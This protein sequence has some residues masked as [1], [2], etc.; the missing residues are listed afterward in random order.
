ME[1]E[2]RKERGEKGGNELKVRSFGDYLGA[3]FE[4]PVPFLG[5]GEDNRKEGKGSKFKINGKM[6]L[7]FLEIGSPDY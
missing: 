3:F 7:G 6:N 2:E 1:K 4:S 5:N